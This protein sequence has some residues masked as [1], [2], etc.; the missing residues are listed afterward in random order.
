MV[1]EVLFQQRPLARNRCGRIFFHARR[2]PLRL[3]VGRNCVQQDQEGSEVVMRRENGYHE[4]RSLK[5]SRR[6]R[7][8]AADA[9]LPSHRD[10]LR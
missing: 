3:L 4:T 7:A 8:F 2:P 6:Y 1:T 9:P 10:D 5:K